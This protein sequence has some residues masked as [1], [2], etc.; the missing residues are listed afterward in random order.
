[1]LILITTIIL[2]IILSII[3][4]FFF[5][6][7][8]FGAPY[9]ITRKESLKNI[10]KLANPKR[11]DLIAELGSGDGRVCI[12]LAKNNQKAKIHGYEINPFLV[13]VSRRKIKKLKLQNQIKIYLKNFWKVNFSKYNKIIFFQFSSITRRLEKKFDRELKKG[14]KVISHNW[15]LPSW[16]IKKQL[17][18]KHLSYGVVYEYEK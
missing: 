13:L 6:P 7:W 10:I 16:K 18:K 4:I 3:L 17:G 9:D 15:K 11:N 12:A 14:T 2:S 8:I 1:M 5:I